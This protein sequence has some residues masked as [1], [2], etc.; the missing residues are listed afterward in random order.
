VQER[1]GRPADLVL[2]VV[3]P[4]PI[5]GAKRFPWNPPG[6]LATNSPVLQD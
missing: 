6:R 2:H 3:L 5:E 4:P 1:V